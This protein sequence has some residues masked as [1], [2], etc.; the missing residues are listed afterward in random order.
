MTTLGT[1]TFIRADN[2]SSWGTA[3]DGNTYTNTGGGTVTISSN[4]GTISHALADTDMQHGTYTSNNMDIVCRITPSNAGDI[5]G[6]EGRYSVSGGNISCYKCLWYGGAIHLNK[7]VSGSS[8]QLTSVTFSVTVNSAYWVRLQVIGSNLTGK[9]WADGSSES[10]A[11]IT[12]TTDTSVT[13]AGGAALIGNT[14]STN[15]IK[16]DSLTVTD[17]TTTSTRTIPATAALQ[18]TLTRTVPTS[19]ALL[20]TSSRV[21]PATSALQTTASRVIPAN[22]SLSAP[23]SSRVIPCAAALQGTLTR[24]VPASVS[25]VAVNALLY[26]RSGTASAFVRGGQ[27][28]AYVR[29]E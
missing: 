23:T 14:A 13:G 12:T 28:T 18:A 1:D 3:S 16:Y 5:F 15:V 26:V 7:N 20:Q 8:S 25:L 10:T 29:E 22:A 17:G 4:H 6:V 21:V 2:P 24:V 9:I 11:T 19:V 27:M